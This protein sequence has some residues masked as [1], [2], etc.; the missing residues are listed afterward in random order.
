MQI[1]ESLKKNLKPGGVVYGT[2]IIGKGVEY[3]FLGKVMRAY[4]NW[5]G[6]LDNYEDSLEG[7]REGLGRH[8]GDVELRVEG[9][10]C[11][12]VCRDPIL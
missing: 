11:L 5:L 3:T 9:M 2:T 4:T 12:F 1:F 7:L 10:V 6:V 8:F